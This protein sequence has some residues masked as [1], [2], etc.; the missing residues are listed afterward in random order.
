MGGEEGEGDGTKLTST[1]AF[2]PGPYKR[3][4]SDR[5]AIDSVRSGLGNH[6]MTNHNLRYVTKTYRN[7]V[8]RR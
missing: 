3:M 5:D 7:S 8:G 1:M 2:R 6:I 4:T